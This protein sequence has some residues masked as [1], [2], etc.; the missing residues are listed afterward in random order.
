M[1]H[2]IRHQ[3]PGKGFTCT[4]GPQEKGDRANLSARGHIQLRSRAQLRGLSTGV[5]HKM[6]LCQP[7]PCSPR[8][9]RG[10]ASHDRVS[11]WTRKTASMRQS[12]ALQT[13][14]FLRGTR[15]YLPRKRSCA[16]VLGSWT[17][18]GRRKKPLQ[19]N[20][21]SSLV[22]NR[23]C[24]RPSRED[25]H[26]PGPG[27]ERGEGQR[28]PG[29]AHRAPSSPNSMHSLWEVIAGQL[30]TWTSSA[31]KYHLWPRDQ[32]PSWEGWQAGSTRQA[33]RP[34][35]ASHPRPGV[36]SAAR[37]ASSP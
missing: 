4:L 7:G 17:G 8:V 10:S 36:C 1:P 37:S 25:G 23:D 19:G 27:E 33:G 11:R 12:G 9:M 21:A 5:L 14:W 24:T 35:Q 32:G 28:R 15:Q 6:S 2:T 3:W 29:P 18:T 16:A 26:S 13:T 22:S 30:L 31:S 34:A 20:H